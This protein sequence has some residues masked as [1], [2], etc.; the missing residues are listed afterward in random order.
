MSALRQL[1]EDLGLSSDQ[2]SLPDT[3]PVQPAANDPQQTRPH[4]NPTH[5]TGSTRQRRPNRA[6][7]LPD[8]I[9]PNSRHCGNLRIYGD[10]APCEAICR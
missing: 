4:T 5:R 2:Q 3:V 8:S 6:A 10:S 7:R 1:A 9:H